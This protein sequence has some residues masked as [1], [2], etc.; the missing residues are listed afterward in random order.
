M[1]A[2]ISS[3][4][5]RH[6]DRMLLHRLLNEECTLTM[7][8]ALIDEFINPGTLFR[9]QCR[10]SIIRAGE[11]DDNLYIIISGIMREWYH[12]NDKEVTQAFG[13][14]GTIVL[15]HHC[16]YAGLPSSTTFEACCPARLLRI[17][18]AD[19]DEL[20]AR[21]AEFARW[22]LRLAQCQ[23]YHYEIK[24]REINGTARERYEKL[25]RHRPEIVK[26]VP[27]KIIASYIGVTP[28]YLSKLRRQITR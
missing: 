10:E 26:N 3:T 18:R 2:H 4:R 28:E 16:Y 15:A 11:T 24:R 20:V 23:L 5:L 13:L 12:E 19:Y 17:R 22:N 6:A 7:P 25:L 14:P 8:A 27:L 9:L 21:N 1:S